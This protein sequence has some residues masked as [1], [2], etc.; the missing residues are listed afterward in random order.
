MTNPDAAAAVVVVAAAVEQEQQKIEQ[1]DVNC[2]DMRNVTAIRDAVAVVAAAVE[3]LVVFPNDSEFAF[4]EFV[5]FELFLPCGEE[6]LE[7]V[8]SSPQLQQ[9]L[10]LHFV[11]KLKVTQLLR[12]I[13]RESFDSVK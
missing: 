5:E 10:L 13:D 1:S 2:H 3:N 11:G 4:V 8:V 12:R 6:V 7:G 9:V